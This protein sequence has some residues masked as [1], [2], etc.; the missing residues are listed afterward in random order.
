[1]PNS[2]PSMQSEVSRLRAQARAALRDGLNPEITNMADTCG[3][4]SQRK[5]IRMPMPFV[6]RSIYC[7]AIAAFFVIAAIFGG[8]LQAGGQITDK[9]VRERVTLMGMQKTALTT[10]S[11]MVAGR[12]VFDATRAKTARRTLINA[13]GNIP[14]YFKKHR[15]DPNSHAR[16][17]IW[18]HW[19]D[20][21]QRAETARQ[22]AKALSTRSLNGLRRTMPAMM[23]ACHSC[24]Q[25]YRNNPNVFITH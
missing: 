19:D 17:D 4:V 25:T 7:S 1:M 8:S 20:F 12:M 2:F 5:T 16:P 9:H 6:W 18:I 21:A 15:M 22:S 14:S 24:H 13:T 11:D 3:I 23:Q 10:L